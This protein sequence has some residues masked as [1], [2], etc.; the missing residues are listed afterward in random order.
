[1]ILI[2]LFSV[3]GGIR[4][5][6]SSFKPTCETKDI[7]KIEDYTIQHSRCIGP[8][9]PHYSSFDIYEYKNHISKAFKVNNDSCKLRARVRNDYYLDFNICKETYLIL[10]PDKRKID[11]EA[12]DSISIRPYDSVRLVRSGKKYPEL[13]YDTIFIANFDSTI[14]KRLNRKEIR[15]FAKRWN[16]S[17]TNGFE[18]LGINYDYVLTLYSN[19]S[20]RKIKTLNHF[21]TENE[22]WSFES[23]EDDFYDKLWN[24]KDKE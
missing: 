11:F 24:D 2:L 17:K 13:F 23:I 22:L 4:Y 12:I 5:F 18:R 1:M 9:G 7:W 14:T 20:I 10:E 21:L 19:D 3:F 16:I 15:D 6:F 8:F